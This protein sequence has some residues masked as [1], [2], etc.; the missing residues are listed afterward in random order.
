MDAYAGTCIVPTPGRSQEP[1][2]YGYPMVAA[3][4]ISPTP[5]RMISH[6]GGGCCGPRLISLSYLRT[7]YATWSPIPLAGF[8]VYK[9][10]AGRCTS[11]TGCP[12]G[13]IRLPAYLFRTTRCRSLVRGVV[14]RRSHP[15]G[16]GGRGMHDPASEL[17]RITLPRTSVHR[18]AGLALGTCL[19]TGSTVAPWQPT[20]TP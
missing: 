10:F 17:R 16:S 18:G 13:S 6:L 20:A 1:K 2:T 15:H 8:L 7:P 9:G 19:G 3:A 11:E 4:A 12:A 14:A 5:T